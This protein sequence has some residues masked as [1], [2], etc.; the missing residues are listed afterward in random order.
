MPK[1]TFTHR[2]VWQQVKQLGR[3]KVLMHKRLLNQSLISTTSVSV[4]IKEHTAPK[5]YV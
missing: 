4:K 1:S 2:I 5:L 3:S